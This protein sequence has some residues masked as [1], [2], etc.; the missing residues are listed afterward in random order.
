MARRADQQARSRRHAPSPRSATSNQQLAV[1]TFNAST[2]VVT[3]VHEVAGR[4]STRRSRKTPQTALRDAP[5]R[6]R[7]AGDRAHP[8]RGHQRRLGRRPL[9]RR[10]HRQQDPAR[11]GRPRTRATANVR[12]FTVGLRSKTF[13]PTRSSSS[14]PTTGGSFSERELAG[15]SRSRST[16][17]S[18]SSSRTST[19]SPTTRSMKPG[20]PGRRQDR[21][22][23]GRQGDAGLRDADARRPERRLP[24][25]ELR[26]ASGSRGWTML[27]RRP[28]HPGAARG[29]DRRARSRT[30]Q[31]HRA[32]ARLRLRLDADREDA[33]PTRSSTAS[34]PGTERSLE[35]TRWWPRFKDALQ[36]ADDRRSR[37]SRSSFGTIV[38]TLFAMWL[39]SLIAPI[40]ALVGLLVPA[41]SSARLVAAGIARKRRLF[42]DQ[43]PDNLD[44][45]ASGLRAGHSLV[46]ALVRRRQRRARAVAHRVPAR[47]RRRAAR[48]VR[49][50]TRST[51]SRS[52]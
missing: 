36:F 32:G 4:R 11:P 39:L 2:N 37:R 29:R 21:R 49:S 18:G 46:G 9:R 33:R 17:S 20:K 31:Q 12:V 47:G 3:L 7:R 42:G 25:V 52:A 24:Q 34:S 16:T 41:A 50:R 10:R 26:A 28:A 19:S 1:L 15:G 38:L 40:L 5:L 44:V 14:R 45:L 13:H 22:R 30:A 8:R 51:A 27:A 6:R 43:L 48:R 35:H 23:R